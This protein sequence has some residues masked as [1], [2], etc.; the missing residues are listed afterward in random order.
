MYPQ[1]PKMLP[2]TSRSEEVRHYN[3]HPF[4]VRHQNNL[5]PERHV[6]NSDIG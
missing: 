1:M 3:S 2:S 6:V 4:S 5:S